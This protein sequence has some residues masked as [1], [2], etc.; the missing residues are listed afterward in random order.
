MSEVDPFGRIT[1]T[2]FLIGNATVLISR[3][4]AART[5]I[6]CCCCGCGPPLDRR[7]IVLFSISSPV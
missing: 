1:G 5:S 6:Y 7:S 3:H 2:D 4:H